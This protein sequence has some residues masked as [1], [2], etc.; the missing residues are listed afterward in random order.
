MYVAVVVALPMKTMLFCLWASV[1]GA[2]LTMHDVQESQFYLK[3]QKWW[4]N[5]IREMQIVAVY[6]SAA[7]TNSE[8]LC[9]NAGTA[10]VQWL[11]QIKQMLQAPG[12]G[13]VT[14]SE[15]DVDK[16]ERLCIDELAGRLAM[17][18][19]YSCAD[20]VCQWLA[21]GL[22]PEQQAQLTPLQSWFL[23]ESIASNKLLDRMQAHATARQRILVTAEQARCAAITVAANA[24]K[25]QWRDAVAGAQDFI[26]EKH[27]PK[28][29]IR[30]AARA[31]SLIADMQTSPVLTAAASCPGYKALTQWLVGAKNVTDTVLRSL[32]ETGDEELWA[33]YD[34]RLELLQ[35]RAPT[36]CD[37]PAFYTWL[38]GT[39]V[40]SEI[41][42]QEF[43]RCAGY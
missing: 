14:L 18:D 38:Y 1:A 32:R 29:A 7:R 5:Q 10:H 12:Y 31:S 6:A 23:A 41:K 28:L 8:R 17:A 37:D 3:V 11:Q 22:L 4:T 13:P 30:E 39:D 2:P 15:T 42:Y 35:H 26:D 34:A 27:L 20:K 21:G 36:A 40:G 43:R 24:Q 16:L 33:H 25:V 19:K 9:Q